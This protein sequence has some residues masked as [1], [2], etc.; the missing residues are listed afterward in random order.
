M[1]ICDKTDRPNG[2]LPW[3]GLSVIRK[4]VIGE[5]EAPQLREKILATGLAVED[6]GSLGLRAI[7]NGTWHVSA[8]STSRVK[9]LGY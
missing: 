4:G 6:S 5:K 9:A 7:S 8:N 1:G 3:E 2:L